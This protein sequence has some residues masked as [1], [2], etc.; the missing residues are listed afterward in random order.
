[1]GQVL[2]T[3]SLLIMLGALGMARANRKVTAEVAHRRWVKF[4][5]YLL[6][7]SL[8]LL[9]I[10]FALFPALSL[11]I[12]AAGIVELWQTRKAA[13]FIPALI[14]LILLFA[15]FLYF[16]FSASMTGQ[17][18]LYIQV[19]TFDAFCQITGQLFGRRP[20][21]PRIS[22][23]KTME[24]LAGGIC[25]CLIVSIIAATLPGIEIGLALVSGI[26]TASAA[27]A[28]DLLASAYKRKAGIKDYSKLLPGQGGV[29]DRFDS[30]V[31]AAFLYSFLYWM[32][33]EWFGFFFHS[34]YHG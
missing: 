4:Y 7:T 8:V 13:F 20:L 32:K 15:G 34:G 16:A 21:A 26:I 6:I 9:S 12:V 25:F 10:R 23:A 22:P 28:G 24:G 2:F 30:L 19:L 18:F 14:V 1:M 33:I 31:M 3:V 27:L 5:S 29:L 11:M 17:L